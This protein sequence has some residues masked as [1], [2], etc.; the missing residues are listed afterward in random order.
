MTFPRKEKFISKIV[1]IILFIFILNLSNVQGQFIDIEPIDHQNAGEFASGCPIDVSDD[2]ETLAVVM[3]DEDSNT[4]VSI[5]NME[6]FE[7]IGTLDLGQRSLWTMNIEINSDGTKIAIMELEYFRIFTVSELLLEKDIENDIEEMIMPQDAAW[8]PDGNFLAVGLNEAGTDIPKVTIYDVNNWSI[9]NELNI[10]TNNVLALDWSQDGRMLAC[11]QGGTT[12]GVGA[13]DVWNTSTWEIITSEPLVDLIVNDLAFD[14][15]GSRLAAGGMEGIQI[16]NITS[17]FHQEIAGENTEI[18]NTVSF[19]DDGEF[20]LTDST[21]WRPGDMDFWGE[22]QLADHGIFIP[23]R[24]EVVTVTITG[25]IDKWDSSDWAAQAA[26]GERPNF[27]ETI[28][29]IDDIPNLMGII[30]VLFVSMVLVLIMII[31]LIVGYK[32]PKNLN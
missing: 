2:G 27:I 15:E 18:L 13:L 30:V 12:S 3:D 32:K 26:L 16:W 8:S 21:F 25:D 10:S 24:N 9:I 11:A 20:L 7:I 23:Q 28:T 31:Y 5:I 19:S 29:V 1:C 14:F 17:S 22:Y 4:I 6:D